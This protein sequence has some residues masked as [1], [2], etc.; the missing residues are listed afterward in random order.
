MIERFEVLSEGTYAEGRSF[1]G[2]TYRLLQ[3]RLHGSVHPADPANSA[4]VDLDRA[5]RAENGA[6]RYTADVTLIT[7]ADGPAESALVDVPNRGNRLLASSFHRVVA[8]N[9]ADTLKPGDGWLLHRGVELVSIGWQW[10]AQGEH[11]MRIDVPVALDDAH[12]GAEQAP[13][14]AE[15]TKPARGEV[16]VELRPDR[17][18]ASLRLLSLGQDAPSY[19][20]VDVN[21]GRL[22]VRDFE[23]DEPSE[24]PRSAW[25]FARVKDGV[26]TPSP[27]HVALDGGFKAGR[28]YQIVH[29]T[30]HAPVV[31]LGLIA[32]RDCAL[33]RRH[34]GVRWLYGFGVSQTGRVLR[35]FLYAGMNQGESG[36]R[37]FDGLL[38]HIAGG[39]RGDFNHR[40]AQPTVA[41]VPSFGQR[42]PFAGATVDDPISGAR[43]GLFRRAE[44]ANCLPKVFFTNTSWEYWRGDA[45]LVHVAPDGSADLPSH[46]SSRT[47][48]FAGTHHIGGILIE[49]KQL[50]QL[51][52]GAR[53][54]EGLNVVVFAPLLRAAFAN[55]DAWVRD[56]TAPP[57][58]ATPRLV[59]GTLVERSEVLARFRTV[60]DISLLDPLKLPVLRRLELGPRAALGIG[61]VLPPAEFERYAAFVSDVDEDLNERAG[62]RLPDIAVPVG[63]HTGWNPRHISSGAGD[64]PATF[65][66]F[67]RLFAPDER[68]RAASHDPRRSIAERYA[69][70]ATYAREVA[71][72]VEGLVAARHLLAED[73][74]WV[75]GNALARY[76]AAVQEEG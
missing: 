45:A 62:I 49:G 58:D 75:T 23:D 57:P 29:E 65:A 61:D 40:F 44:A 31:G 10:D 28:I 47:Y 1:S 34:Q 7:P 5:Q 42:F 48:L 24:L 50:R 15:A 21:G 19:P 76:D 70:R 6:V 53:V 22:L 39:Q 38:I 66:G 25:R 54:A 43:D 2:H 12:A 51:P 8:L 18:A 20:V 16:M 72:C 36:Q 26:A 9:P 30:T 11:A 13:A 64:Q 32:I 55:L 74:E 73:A 59:D 71:A 4:I 67:T 27:I 56:G 17:D 63:S 35:H 52:L 68:R 14:D 60:P 37:A 3:G 41:A 46:P 33:W 69:D